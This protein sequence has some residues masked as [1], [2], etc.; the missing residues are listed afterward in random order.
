MLNENCWWYLNCEN[1]SHKDEFQKNKVLYDDDVYLTHKKTGT[2]LS[3][4][5]FYRSPRTSY[6]EVHCFQFALTNLKFIKN[7]QTN[8]E[9]KTPYLKARDRVYL[10]TE[11]DYM[12]RSQDNDK[13]DTKPLI[14]QEVV[15]HKEKIGR[16]DE[17]LIEKR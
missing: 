16:D 10:R 3:M 1:Q 2:T 11:T 13:N 8:Q 7:D 15:G 14:F 6:A 9:N 4:S 12:L 5:D 17:W